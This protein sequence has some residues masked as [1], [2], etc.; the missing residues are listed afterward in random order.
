MDSS[1]Q[2][3]ADYYD[4]LAS[5]FD[6]RFKRANP[7]H[8]YKISQ[9]ARALFDGLPADRT[10]PLDLLEVGGGTGI[11]AEA[12]LD[13]RGDRVGTFVLA[14]LS[15]AMLEQARKRLGR[16]PFV[17]YLAGPAESLATPRVFDGIYVS[18]AMHHF[19]RPEAS[20]REMASHLKPGGVLVVCEPIVSNPLNFVMAAKTREEWGQFRVTRRRVRRMMAQAG[21]EPVSE[22]VLHW[23]A[24]SPLLER[25]WPHEALTAFP[26]L[27]R[28]AVMFLV[29][30]RRP[31]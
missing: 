7:N 11:H 9:I 13:E 10:G 17:E 15:A 6:E 31:T 30:G 18:G 2:R 23:K 3:Q 29:A 8:L 20:V 27:D 1:Q 28:L 5:D 16:F 14:D 24:G 12:F 19:S 22:R 21:L 26:L 4:R 25:L